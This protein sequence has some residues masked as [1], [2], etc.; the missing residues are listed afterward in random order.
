MISSLDKRASYP[1]YTEKVSR[2][3]NEFETRFVDLKFFNYV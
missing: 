3:K 1:K 2:L